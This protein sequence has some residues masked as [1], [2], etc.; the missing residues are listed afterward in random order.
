MKKIKNLTTSITLFFL[1]TTFAFAGNKTDEF[2]VNGKCNMCENRIEKAANSV[3]GVSGS[4]WDSETQKLS[5]S[6]DDQQT[7]LKKIETAIAMVGHD[8]EMFRASD[9][10][11]A[12]LPGCCQYQREQSGEKAPHSTMSTSA[13]CTNHQTKGDSCCGDK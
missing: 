9:T 7:D 6:Y 2:K 8:T 11:Y 13:G 5:V 10:R 12:E 4:H 3:N 1:G